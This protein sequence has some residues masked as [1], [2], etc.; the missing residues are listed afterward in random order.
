MRKLQKNALVYLN[1]PVE[2]RPL[3]TLLTSPSVVN[4]IKYLSKGSVF[5]VLDENPDEEGRVKVISLL[6]KSI[7]KI[8][9]HNFSP[10]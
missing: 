10:Y 1:K 7:F 9:Y 6:D 2:E 4:E 3:I 8:H 5:L